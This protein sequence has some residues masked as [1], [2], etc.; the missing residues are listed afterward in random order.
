MKWTTSSPRPDYELRPRVES[1]TAQ[2]LCVRQDAHLPRFARP[3]LTARREEQ[4]R[5]DRSCG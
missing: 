1:E 4:T 3:Q 5:D 2:F